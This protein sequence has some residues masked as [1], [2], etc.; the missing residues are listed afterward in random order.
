MAE[1]P[2]P[3][4]GLRVVDF[5]VLAAGPLTSK[6]LADYGAEV[7][8]VESELSIAS[9]GGGRQAGPPGMSPINT[10]W[11]HNKYNPNKLSVTVDLSLPQGQDIV[12]RLVAISDVFVANRTPQVLDKLGVSYEALR[13][14]KPD[15]IYLTM[16]TMGAGGK[17][18]F[19]GGVSWGIQAMA[20]LN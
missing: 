7:I 1:G 9:S 12:K 14:V 8:I 20:G 10:A 6:L 13:A 2:L 19:Y 15:L 18:S 5:S 11:F 17:R 4:A 3:L 16:P